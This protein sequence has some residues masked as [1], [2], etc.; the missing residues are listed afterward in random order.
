MDKGMMD[1]LERLEQQYEEA[2]KQGRY[3][4]FWDKRREYLLEQA[5]RLSAGEKPQLGYEEGA[6]PRGLR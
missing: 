5:R 6:A 3:Q 4:R 1:K 2:K